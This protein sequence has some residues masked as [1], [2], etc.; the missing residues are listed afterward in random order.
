MP[1]APYVCFWSVYV[2]GQRFQ[3]EFTT[4]TY[5]FYICQADQK[6][7]EAPLVRRIVDGSTHGDTDINNTLELRSLLHMSHM[8][9]RLVSRPICEIVSMCI[10]Y[11]KFMQTV[12][13]M[14]ICV[15]IARE[16][17]EIP[18]HA[19]K[20]VGLV[21]IHWQFWPTLACV[22]LIKTSQT[23]LGP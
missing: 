4:S 16:E 20:I 12:H 9:R 11:N 19:C 14:K 5:R 8:I 10:Y 6:G 22:T 3:V 18:M 13:A 7:S 23:S 1:C 21:C 17:T 15:N 2:F